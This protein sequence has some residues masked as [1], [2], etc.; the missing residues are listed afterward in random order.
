MPK[1][2]FSCRAYSSMV[3]KSKAGPKSVGWYMGRPP[4]AVSSCSFVSRETRREGSCATLRW[5]RW[6]SGMGP[7]WK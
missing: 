5:L 2:V 1:F 6:A 3:A 4:I 7:G